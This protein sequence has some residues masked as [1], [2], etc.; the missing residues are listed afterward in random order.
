[1]IIKCIVCD[2]EFDNVEKIDAFYDDM[3][4]YFIHSKCVI[5]LIK[6]YIN[7]KERAIEWNGYLKKKGGSPE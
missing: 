6:R 4:S 3:E 2:K 1:M 5:S 7:Q